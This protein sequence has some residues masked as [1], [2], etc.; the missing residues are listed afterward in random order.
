MLLLERNYTNAIKLFNRVLKADKTNIHAKFYRGI[1]WLDL[2]KPQKAVSV[3]YF[4]KFRI[5]K[6]FLILSRT[7]IKLCISVSLWHYEECIRIKK[8]FAL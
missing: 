2:Q 1:A 7:I 8:Q 5:F 4:F 6:T 3:S